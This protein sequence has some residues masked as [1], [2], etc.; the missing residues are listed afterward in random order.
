MDPRVMELR[1]KN[2]IPLI[3]E[4]AKSGMTKNEWCAMHGIERTTFFRWQK[5]V[6]AYLLDQCE[7]QPL[8]LPSSVPSNNEVSFVELPAIQGSTVGTAGRRCGKTDQ[9][10]GAS[11]FI[12]IRYGDF[13]IDLGGSVDEGQLA[14]VLKVIKNAD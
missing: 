14:T 3:E 1:I 13:S 2:W 7:N 4:Q 8:Q 10:C 12:S 6:R 9:G 11:P 5:R